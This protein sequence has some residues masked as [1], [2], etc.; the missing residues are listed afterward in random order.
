MRHLIWMLVLIPSITFA[1]PAPIIGGNATTVGQFPS[2]VAL[3]IG[4]GLCTG[5]LITPE[6]VL[7]AAHCVT[8][9]LVGLPSQQA[10]TASVRVHFNSVNIQQAPGMIVMASQTIPKPGFSANNLGSNDIGLIKLATAVTI[11][12]P[13]PVNLDPAAAP[14]GTKV[15]MVGYGATRQGGGG[16]FGIQFAL[17]NRTSTSCT[18][19]GVSDANLLCFSQ[20]DNKGKCQGDSGG[21]SFAQIQGRTVVVG[22]TSFGDQNCAQ[23]GADTRTDAERT[24]LMTHVP[25]IDT[26][27]VDSDCA[28]DQICFDDK[29]IAQPFG[30]GGLGTSCTA[31]SECAS[32]LCAEGPDGKLCSEMCTVGGASCPDGFECVAATNG[33]GACWPSAIADGGGCCDSSGSGAATMAFGIGLLALARRQRRPRSVVRPSA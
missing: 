10:V 25:N 32:G 22:V 7:T 16:S 1:D 8:P 26:C 23:F 30:P 5:T 3:R 18:P 24:F 9:S 31:G 4:Q 28:V 17:E 6:W 33:Q 12:A 20:T 2:V 19:F 11:V 13:T 27:E 15:T 29:C 21:P 14:I